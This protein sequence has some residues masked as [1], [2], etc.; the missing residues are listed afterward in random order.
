M[1]ALILLALLVFTSA[2][3]SKPFQNFSKGLLEE[4][5]FTKV[6]DS[7]IGQ[8]N[9]PDEDFWKASIESIKLID[10]DKEDDE[11]A[12]RAV[13]LQTGG[14]ALI[15][16]KIFK[17]SEE[18]E[19]IYEIIEKIHKI[20]DKKNEF[21]EKV[22]EKKEKVVED[23]KELVNHWKDSGTKDAGKKVGEF[24]SWFYLTKSP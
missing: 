13:R 6:P 12:I 18:K 4:L 8:L 23:T 14:V 9:Y 24:I 2:D 21:E 5:E 16:A 22:R 1:K 10:W 11:D 7:L 20:I 19:R 17:H 15:L 3:I